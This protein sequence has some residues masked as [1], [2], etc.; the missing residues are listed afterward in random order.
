MGDRVEVEVKRALTAS[1]YAVL[2]ARLTMLGFTSAGERWLCDYYLAFAV[3]SPGYDFIRLRRSGAGAVLTEK[4][5]GRDSTGAPIRLE[6]EHAIS[7]TE[8]DALLRDHPEA[9]LLEKKRRTFHGTIAGHDA[10]C[11]LDR[12]ILNGDAS[13]YIEA[14]IISTPDDATAVHTLLAH[15][16]T[17]TL[18]IPPDRDAPSMLELL[19]AAEGAI[20]WVE[21]ESEPEGDV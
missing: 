19:L 12:I 21:E 3:V 4:H 11:V 17:D 9:R 15:W 13:C 14:E 6:E 7:P 2:P 20:E 5:W 8:A 16:L 1:E 10:E 18:H